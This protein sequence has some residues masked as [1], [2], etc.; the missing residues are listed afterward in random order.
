M[1]NNDIISIY[2]VKGDKK[3]IGDKVKELRK[4]LGITQKDLAEHLGL[5]SQTT[6]AAIE[7]NK[8]KPSNEL[9]S[10]MS[11][12]FNVSTDF[13]LEKVNHDAGYIRLLLSSKLKKHMKDENLTLEDLSKKLN[14]PL[15]QLRAIENAEHSVDASESFKALA[16]YVKLP[17]EENNL[18]MYSAPGKPKK[19]F[20]ASSDL[21]SMMA[22]DLVNIPIVGVVRAGTPILAV[23]NIEGYIP[24]PRYMIN[25]SKEYFG[26]TVKGD[27]MNLEFKEGSTIIVEKTN[28]VE[29]GQIGLILVDGCDATVKKIVQQNNMITLIPMSSNSDHVP[30]MY[31]LKRDEVQ[32]VGKV[33]HAI[34]S[35]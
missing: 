12:L 33:K 2:C 8:N 25:D 20:I 14:L 15:E 29:N 1:I 3:M 23:E 21:T 5:K 28:V 19:D 26:L 11:D 31:D 9:L 22:N 35:Y 32:I 7:N 27:S 13:L 10:R 24:L 16:D 17:I 34:K 30:T 4:L 18:L 6:I